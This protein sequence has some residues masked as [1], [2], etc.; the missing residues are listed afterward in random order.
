MLFRSTEIRFSVA[1]LQP[2]FQ[3]VSDY[4]TCKLAHLSTIPTFRKIMSFLIRGGLS[5]VVRIMPQNAIICCQ[6]MQLAARFQGY[7]PICVYSHEEAEQEF[8]KTE[9]RNGLRF[10][11]HRLPIQYKIDTTTGE[12]EIYNISTGGCAAVF[13]LGLPLSVDMEIIISFSFTEH[14]NSKEIGRASCR[15]RV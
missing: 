9:K 8:A 2:G 6:I 14:A 12:G 15:E 1:D 4:S 7:S 13:S 11:L 5:D 3:V 10:H